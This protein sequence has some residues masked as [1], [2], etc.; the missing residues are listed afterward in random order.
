[1]NKLINNLPND[2]INIIISYTY[3]L[4]PLELRNDIISYVETKSII[5]NIFYLK[6]YNLFSIKKN[7]DLVH[8]VFQLNCFNIGLQNIYSSCENNIINLCNRN[9][10]YSNNK[11]YSIINLINISYPIVNHEIRFGTVWGLLTSE[12]RNKFISFNL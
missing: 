5:R 11:N 2:V 6:Y 12:E 7:A 8:L 1:M 10:M 3:K 9:Y 4:Q